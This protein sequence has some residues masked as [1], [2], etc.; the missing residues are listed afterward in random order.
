[1]L[2]AEAREVRDELRQFAHLVDHALVAG[3]D[4]LAPGDVRQRVIA[5][6]GGYRDHPPHVG[7]QLVL[8]R[9]HHE[10]GQIAAHPVVPAVG[11]VGV[12]VP[13]AGPV[14]VGAQETGPDEVAPHR[15]E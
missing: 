12:L 1:M 5:E 6:R 10:L 13:A 8:V 9:A 11:R 7:R 14:Q 4:D 15:A 3:G 2:A